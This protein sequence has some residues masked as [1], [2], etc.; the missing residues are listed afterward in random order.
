MAG[1][2]RAIFYWINNWPRS[3]APTFYFFSEATK[4]PGYK[5]NIIIALGAI[6]LAMV[7]RGGKPR[8]AALLALL[9]WPLANE[10]SEAFKLAIPLLRPCNDL[11]NVQMIPGIG[12]LTTFGT[13][14]SHAANMAAVATVFTFYL[15]GWATPWIIVAV[16]TGLSRIYVGL[17]YPSQVLAGWTCGAFCGTVVVFSWRAFLKSRNLVSNE[18]VEIIDASHQ[19]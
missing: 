11:P 18:P 12:P 13:V 3:F 15:R 1:V 6:L 10:F 16:L 5:K 9:A 17:H 2:D 7:V 19:A 14:S 4:D 8:T